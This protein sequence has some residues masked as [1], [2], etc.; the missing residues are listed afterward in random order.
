VYYGSRL[1]AYNAT[2]GGIARAAQVI[3]G[4]K[5]VL[6]V[7][8]LRPALKGFHRQADA[9]RLGYVFQ[10]LGFSKLADLVAA[11]LPPHPEIVQLQKGSRSA[12]RSVGYDSRW[13]VADNVGLVS[14]LR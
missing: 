8:G 6:T 12:E 2:R 13:H 4:L 5:P 14:H 9:Q 1:V 10:I 3:A 7:F 11:E